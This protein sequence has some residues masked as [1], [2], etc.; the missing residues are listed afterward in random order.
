[1]QQL[2]RLFTIIFMFSLVSTLSAQEVVEGMADFSRKEKGNA[3]SITVEGQ[4][5]NVQAVMDDLFKKGT[6]QKAKSKSGLRM[7]EGARFADISG[8]NMDYFYKVNRPSRGDKIHSKVTLFISSGNNNFISSEEFPDEI[9]GAT[10][11]LNG[12]QLHV[13]IYEM[14]LVIED[15]KKLI[16]KEE[17]SLSAMGKDSVKLEEMLL[18]TQANIEQNKVDQDNQRAK[19]FSENERLS[20]FRLQLDEL[21]NR[22]D[23]PGMIIEED[24]LMDAVDETDDGVFESD[25]DGGGNDE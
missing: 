1:M 24:I 3:L 18:Q 8:T 22:R 15:Q 13:N 4:P 23:N 25:G 21:K 17:K 7:M 5:K 2:Q 19:I 9:S 11:V 12:L 10:E 16:Q 14:E 6:G 20:T